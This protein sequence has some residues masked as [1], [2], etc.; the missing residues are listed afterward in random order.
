MRAMV[1]D[2]FGGPEE[3]HFAE[4]PT[5]APGT[6]EV[7][8]RLAYAAVNPAD[9]KCRAGWFAPYADYEFPFIIGLD[10][11]GIIAAVG[12]GVSA[13]KP[14]DRVATKANQAEKW[15]TYAE[16]VRTEAGRVAA[17]GSRIPLE[18]A[19]TVPTCGISAWEGIDHVGHVQAGQTVL[20]H[21]GAGG[22][23]SLAI[24]IARLFGTRVAAT[25]GPDNLEYVRSLGAERAID[26][27]SENIVEAVTAWA[28]GGVDFAFDCVGQGSFKDG[29]K[30]VKRGGTF[31][32]I[33]T[34]IP[35]EPIISM[36]EGA[37]AGVKVELVSSNPTRLE[38]QLA[39][40]MD[41]FN[42][43]QLRAPAI[44]IM[45]L[46]QVAEAHRRVEDGH[47]RGKIVLK[48]AEL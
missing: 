20:V 33:K 24:Q 8:I 15:G 43:G 17:V 21:G 37:K 16:Y 18:E 36:E 41:A 30:A 42:K 7:V 26:Y 5:P 23:G 12:P 29:L 25:C 10:G 1:I 3:F 38:G 32:Y 48:I 28:P 2:R 13:F 31:G 27:R 35:D 44:A 39:R 40:V 22:T 34:V 11:A 14:G 19:A 9:W 46:E 4:V 6:G 47:V 45:P